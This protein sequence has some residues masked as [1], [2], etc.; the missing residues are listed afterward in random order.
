MSDFNYIPSYQSEV[1]DEYAVDLAQFGDGYVATAPDGINPVKEV[2][3]LRFDNIKLVDGEAIR[4]FLKTK[5]GLSF[6]WTPPGG[7]EKRWRHIG[8]VNM[9]RIGSAVVNLT[10]VFEEYFGA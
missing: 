9:P 2:W 1:S 8:G 3:R 6:T 5:A 10:C 4:A 7:T